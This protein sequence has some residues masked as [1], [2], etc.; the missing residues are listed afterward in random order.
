MTNGQDGEKPEF[1]DVAKAALYWGISPDDAIRLPV[2][3]IDAAAIILDAEAKVR[4]NKEK[5]ANK[6]KG[7]GNRFGWK[8]RR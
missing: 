5:I 4:E 1:Y 2:Y 3:W 7:K 6:N 8:R